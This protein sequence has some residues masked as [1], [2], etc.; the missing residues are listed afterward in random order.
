MATEGSETVVVRSKPTR[1]SVGDETPGAIKGTKKNALIWPRT[2]D[3]TSERGTRVI[4]GLMIFLPDPVGFEIVATDRI[5]ARGK[6]WEV[7]GAAGDYRKR[8]GVKKG[9]LVATI[10]GGV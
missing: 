2:S 3:E 7:D 10:R 4:D 8:S 6:T 5:E 1:S 9:L